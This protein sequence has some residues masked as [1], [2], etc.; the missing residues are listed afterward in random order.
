VVDAAVVV[1]AA[2]RGHLIVASD[3]GDL[4]LLRGALHVE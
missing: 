3:P 4:N 1:G 2:A